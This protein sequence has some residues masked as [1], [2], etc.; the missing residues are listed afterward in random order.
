MYSAILISHSLLRWLV[1]LCAVW[2]LFRAATG[3]DKPWEAADETPRKWLP[4]LF[5]VQF[6]VGLV[7]VF[8]SPLAQTAFGN[9]GAAMKDP[10]LRFFSVEHTFAMFIALALVHIGG[11][12]ARKGATPAAKRKAMLIF[13]GLATL[14]MAW[15]IPWASRPMIRLG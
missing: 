15:A 1:L 12:R 9:M 6:L 4:I 13:F 5:T 3:G 10:T 7:L 11:A 2:A 14:V 8:V